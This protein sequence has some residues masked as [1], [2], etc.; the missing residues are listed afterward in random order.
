M[1]PQQWH[2][3]PLRQTKGNFRQEKSQEQQNAAADTNDDSP[4]PSEATLSGLQGERNFS[5]I[6]FRA[7]ATIFHNALPVKLNL[8]I[9]EKDFCITYYC[10]CKKKA[11]KGRKSN[12]CFSVFYEVMATLSSGQRTTNYPR[13]QP[14]NRWK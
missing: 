1:Q 11:K 8:K 2:Q 14:D 10:Y 5:N 9:V 12:I 3:R 6:H 4:T 7:L 13:L